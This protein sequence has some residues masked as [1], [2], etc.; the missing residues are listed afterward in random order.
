M[1]RII[2]VFSRIWTETENLSTFEKNGYNSAHV[3]ENTDQ[4]IFFAIFW[5]FSHSGVAMKEFQFLVK[6][7]TGGQ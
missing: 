3:G 6:L 2:P 7:E 4:R 5:H 1:N